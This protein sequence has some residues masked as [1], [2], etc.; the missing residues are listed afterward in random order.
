MIEEV[1]RKL[2]E[3]P[4]FKEGNE[5]AKPDYGRCVDIATLGAR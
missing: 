3:I 5:E 1:R 2:M 4:G